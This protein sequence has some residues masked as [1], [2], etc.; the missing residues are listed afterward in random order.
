MQ[1]NILSAVARLSDRH[2]LDEVKRLAARER[3]VTAELVA[4]L[5]EIEERGLHKAAGFGSMFEYCREVLQ[6]SEHAAYGR[7]A[8]ARAARKFPVILDM[9][10]DGSLNLTTVGLL[11]R[12]LT[13]DNYRAVLAEAM[14]RSKSEVEELV[15]RIHPQPDVPPS[16]RQLPEAKP[17]AAP[18]AATA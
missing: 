7:I 10:A 4:H 13:R 6:L 1:T 2:L 12:H 3:D 16:I 5:A 18:H 9:L 17:V 11:G 14:G 8:A 15:A